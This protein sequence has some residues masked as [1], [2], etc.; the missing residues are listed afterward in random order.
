MN[1]RQHQTQTLE[2]PVQIC[3]EYWQ[4]ECN[5]LANTLVL[6]MG[7]KEQYDAWCDAHLP[8]ETVVIDWQVLYTLLDAEYQRRLEIAQFEGQ[9]HREQMREERI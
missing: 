1:Y 5:R 3:T 7:G 8:G 9:D 4:R 2:R 6:M